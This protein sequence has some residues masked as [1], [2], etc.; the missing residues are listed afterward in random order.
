MPKF[1]NEIIENDKSVPTSSNGTIVDIIYV[2][3]EEFNALEANGKLVE[4]T[5]YMIDETEET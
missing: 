4:N 1:L 2:T 5:I 3:S